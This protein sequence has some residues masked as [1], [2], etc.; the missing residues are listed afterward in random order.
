MQKLTLQVYV[1]GSVEAV[2]LYKNAFNTE[3]TASYK[4]SDGTFSHAE[5]EI[6][7]Q[8][9]AVS[10]SWFNE[11]IKG[12][13]MQFIFH[14]GEENEHIIQKAYDVLKD[15]ATILHELGPIGWSSF[16]FALIDKYGVSWCIAV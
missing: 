13:T 4:N 14:F 12:N 7:G 6:N 8:T 9:F 2:E 11:A 15:G 1:R 10:E 16:A 3:L 5:F